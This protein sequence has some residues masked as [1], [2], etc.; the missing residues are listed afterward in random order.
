ML[1]RLERN[2]KEKLRSQGYQ[3]DRWGNFRR[4]HIGETC[5]ERWKIGKR[6]V[7]FETRGSYSSQ[8]NRV[9]SYLYPKN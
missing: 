1:P 7:R 8:W 3:E 2:W 6:I 4:M 9:R 5:E